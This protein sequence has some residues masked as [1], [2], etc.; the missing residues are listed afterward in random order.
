MPNS[1]ICRMTAPWQQP[2]LFRTSAI[3]HSLAPSED[4]RT[5]QI[6]EG[7]AK[8]MRGQT[9]LTGTETS[10]AEAVGWGAADADQRKGTIDKRPDGKC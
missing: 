4:R 7:I 3:R 5:E 9:F 10:L 6:Q 1:G 8:D 2:E